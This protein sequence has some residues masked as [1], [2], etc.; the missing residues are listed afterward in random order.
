[1]S[2]LTPLVIANWKLNGNLDLVNA[3]A[4]TFAGKTFAAQIAVCPPAIY[5][6]DTHFAIEETPLLVGGQNCSRYESG[7]F[8]GE[9]SVSML[10]GAGCDLCLIGHSERR[11]IFSET[12][13]DCREKIKLALQQGLK[14][15]LCIGEQL[16]EREA[17]I[18][19]EVVVTQLRECLQGIDLGSSE[20]CIAYEPVWAIGTG[21]A[22]TPE[23][24]QEVH[25]FIRQELAHL[26]SSPVAQR[27]PI[28]YGGSV[29]KNNT[30][31]L[32]KQ[33]DIDGLLVGG[34]SLDVTHFLSICELA[35][36]SVG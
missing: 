16:A 2:S 23:M 1:M 24:A 17:N 36:A 14:P 19:Q 3:L 8:T 4:T 27:T 18:T 13:Q 20:I 10:K 35:S 12:N 30:A 31:E 33:L 25:A 29:N 28:L 21:L 7:A 6:R 15:V 11:A 32:M 26:Y 9:I 34:A 22:A 5:L